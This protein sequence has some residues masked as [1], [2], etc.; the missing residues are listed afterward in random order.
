MAERRNPGGRVNLRFMG[1]TLSSFLVVLN[2]RCLLVLNRKY[3]FS[4][5]LGIWIWS[6]G[7]GS[8]LEIP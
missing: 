5:L 1:D 6:S 7:D 2:L 3:V 8:E 4:S